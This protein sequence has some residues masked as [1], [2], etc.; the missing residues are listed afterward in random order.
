MLLAEGLSEKESE[1]VKDSNELAEWT[2]KVCKAAGAP[3]DG[4]EPKW[5]R[6]INRPPLGG[7]RTLPDPSG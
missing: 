4:L 7:C 1:R 2:A 6:N 3:A 5:L